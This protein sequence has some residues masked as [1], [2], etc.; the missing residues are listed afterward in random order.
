M[1]LLGW[2][3]D[4]EVINMMPDCKLA[5]DYNGTL[6]HELCASL[7]TSNNKGQVGRLARDLRSSS[8]VLSNIMY[9]RA[10]ES[11]VEQVAFTREVL[12]NIETA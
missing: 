5:D 11:L 6:P 12:E 8:S 9:P 2:R 7:D 10:N 3:N 1:E 4:I